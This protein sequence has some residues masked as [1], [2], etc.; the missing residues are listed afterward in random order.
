VVA[1]ASDEGAHHG[2]FVGEGG[3]FR[4]RAAEGDAGKFGGHLAGGAADFRRGC[5]LGVERLNLTG[6]AVQK[7]EDDRFAGDEPSFRAR[8]SGEQIGERQTA[9]RQST[10]LQERPAAAPTIGV[11]YRKHDAALLVGM[12][13]C[14]VFAR[15]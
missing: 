10:D 12:E 1:V 3:Q 5:H 14:A 13:A 15:G 9:Q 2:Q 11:V 6:T 7:E 8:A 4:K